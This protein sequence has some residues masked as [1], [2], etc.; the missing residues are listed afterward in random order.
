MY[1]L[2]VWIAKWIPIAQLI[3]YRT[4]GALADMQGDP[5]GKF[6]IL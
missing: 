4:Q 1:V 6:S 2:L 5:G 3:S